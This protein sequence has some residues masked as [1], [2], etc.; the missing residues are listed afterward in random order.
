MRYSEPCG[1]YHAFL[2]NRLLLTRKVLTQVFLVV[3]LKS[4]LR[5]ME[6]NSIKM[7]F[8]DTMTPHRSSIDVYLFL[9]CTYSECKSSH[10]IWYSLPLYAITNKT[11]RNV[12]RPHVFLYFSAVGSIVG[13]VIGSLVVIGIIISVIV[14]CAKKSNR[15]TGAI[16]YPTPSAVNTTLWAQQQQQPGIIQY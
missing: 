16:I 8:F 14:Y 9:E 6:L 13:G 3:K 2:Y 11:N 10:V 7:S 15:S 1:S 12:Q 5:S 4:S